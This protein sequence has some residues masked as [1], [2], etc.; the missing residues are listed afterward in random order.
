MV[1]LIPEEGS[2]NMSAYVTS[3]GYQRIALKGYLVEKRNGETWVAPL[4]P[5]LFYGVEGT[6]LQ[7][8]RQY[9]PEAGSQTIFSRVGGEPSVPRE[10]LFWR[11]V[12]GEKPTEEEEYLAVDRVREVK[13]L[14]P[15]IPLG[16][17]LGL[18]VLGWKL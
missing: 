13:P 3:P 18:L 12:K 14:F 7:T 17:G 4:I 16:V 9:L 10:E 2:F 1:L 6:Q 8:W 11:R 15:L 5:Q